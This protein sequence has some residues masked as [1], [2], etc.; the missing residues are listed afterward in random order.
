MHLLLINTLKIKQRILGFSFVKNVIK[1]E[2]Y[3]PNDFFTTPRWNQ[4]K[5]N[6]FKTY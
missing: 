6:T 3:L 1:L 2:L 4:K 5:R